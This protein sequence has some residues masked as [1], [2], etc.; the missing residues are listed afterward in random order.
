MFVLVGGKKFDSGS[1]PEGC[2]AVHCTI[3]GSDCLD[4]SSRWIWLDVDMVF[5]CGPPLAL[6]T[7]DPTPASISQVR[8]YIYN[9]YKYSWYKGKTIEKLFKLLSSRPRL[10][11]IWGSAWQTYHLSGWTWGHVAYRMA[12]WPKRL[13]RWT[14]GPGVRLG[15]PP[16][17]GLKSTNS[18]ENLVVLT[19]PKSAL[20]CQRSTCQRGG[21]FGAFWGAAFARSWSSAW[22]QKTFWKREWEVV[23]S[24]VIPPK[25][26]R[27]SVSMVGK[28]VLE[29]WCGTWQCTLALETV[30]IYTVHICTRLISTES[31]SHLI[32][33]ILQILQ[34]FIEG[35]LSPLKLWSTSRCSLRFRLRLRPPFVC[36]AH[37][38]HGLGWRHSLAKATHLRLLLCK[39]YIYARYTLL[40]K[41]TDIW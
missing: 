17:D 9:I 35:L 34:S 39:T 38:H 14:V 1:C 19:Q 33:C 29:V 31:I 15:C 23:C 37:W 28:K 26:Q 6:S 16:K 20:N 32:F 18:Y 5:L 13:D 7:L 2:W 4:A 22:A 41:T 12:W 30:Q 40:S 25:G 3:F 24:P 27:R 8:T 36:E 10:T 21:A 11:V